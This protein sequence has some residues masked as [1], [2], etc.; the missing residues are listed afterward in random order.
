[1]GRRSG[2]P[3]S[4]T[5]RRWKAPRRRR[6]PDAVAAR[7]ERGEERRYPTAQAPRPRC[8][9]D[10]ALAAVHLIAPLAREIAHPQPYI[11]LAGP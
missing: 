9:A 2:G 6:C 10:S 5:G 3:P 8:A 4:K 11:T 7:I 1:M